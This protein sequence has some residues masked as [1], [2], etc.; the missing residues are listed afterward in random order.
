[1]AIAMTCAEEQRAD[2][3]VV[4]ACDRNYLRFAVFAAAQIAALSPGRS[5]DICLCSLET[6]APVPGL[7]GHGFRHCRI[8]TKG[9]FSGLGLDARRTEASYLRLALPAAFAGAYRRLLYLDS[10]VFVQGGDF[11]AL[12][13]CDIG[14]HPL[15]AVRDNVQWRT[16]GR[17]PPSFRRLG[18]SA[19]RCFNSGVLL[20][21]VAAY[22]RQEVL[23]RCLEFAR[24]H[25]PK[26]I[27]LDQD[28]V[29]AV[30]HGGWAELSPVWNW[31]YTWASRLFEAMAD[32]HVVHFIGSKKPW[33]HAG[34]EL[35][36]RFRRAYRAFLAAH[37]P[38]APPVGEDGV[39]PM[40][41]RPFLQKS[42]AKHLV[43]ARKMSAYLERFPT[44]LTVLT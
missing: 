30:L 5:F 32:A 14:P 38:D 12:L 26:R 18:L 42:L 17:S 10:D 34:G 41:N 20:I 11:G 3:A 19:A 43:S 22:G 15:A 16:P 6:L 1:M 8:E 39:A 35:P 13:A 4:F 29:N 31:Q 2:S 9:I 37:F 40:A 7:A 33:S 25:P 28:L 21:D 24:A 44:D 27:G 36:L 23:A